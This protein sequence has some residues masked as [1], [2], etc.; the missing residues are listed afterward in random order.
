MIH[1]IHASNSHLWI[2]AHGCL[3]VHSRVV[4]AAVQGLEPQMRIAVRVFVRALP[5]S[6]QDRFF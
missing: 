5:G 3:G 6:D 4:Q 2:E 1:V